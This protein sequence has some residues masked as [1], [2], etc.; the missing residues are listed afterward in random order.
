MGGRE[1]QLAAG[2][3]SGGPGDGGRRDPVCL[4]AQAPGIGGDASGA[5]GESRG[6]PAAA[7]EGI[8]DRG[9]GAGIGGGAGNSGG[10]GRG[11]VDGAEDFKLAGSRA[12]RGDRKS[13]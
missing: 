6:G 13:T 10:N 12:D 11:G 5:V 9:G 7:A 2:I 4:G 3:W 8:D 1:N